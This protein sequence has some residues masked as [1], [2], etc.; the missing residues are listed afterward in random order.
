MVGIGAKE[1]IQN[2][3]NSHE[4]R[5]KESFLLMALHFFAKI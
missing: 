2:S 4:I 5:E 3:G 1:S